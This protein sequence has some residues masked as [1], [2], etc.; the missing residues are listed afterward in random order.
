MQNPKLLILKA[1]IQL[2]IALHHGFKNIPDGALCHWVTHTN[3]EVLLE[4]PLGQTAS[5]GSVFG[6]VSWLFF[7]H[8]LAPWAFCLI[9]MSLMLFIDDTGLLGWRR[10]CS[11]LLKIC[12]RKVGCCIS[13]PGVVSKRGDGSLPHQP[14][15][16]LHHQA[17]P[18]FYPD[19][20]NGAI[21]SLWWSWLM[22]H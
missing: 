6:L 16:P 18:F 5:S 2:N 15:V 11:P 13:T 20:P 21:L 9:K 14:Q 7:F 19:S 10:V 3:K 4:M 1:V 8:I 17:A 12:S 22:C